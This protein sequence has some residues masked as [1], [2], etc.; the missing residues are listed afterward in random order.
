MAQLS[1]G[2]NMYDSKQRIMDSYNC[3]ACLTYEWKG[4]VWVHNLYIA[5]T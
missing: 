2:T 1:R 3:Y 4:G 5:T